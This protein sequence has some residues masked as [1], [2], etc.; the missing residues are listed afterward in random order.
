MITELNN[1][2]EAAIKEKEDFLKK[3]Q[4]EYEAKSQK[5]NKDLQN[6]LDTK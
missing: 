5:L 6:E 3:C 4:A 2:V 1:K